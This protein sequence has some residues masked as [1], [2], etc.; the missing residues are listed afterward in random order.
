VIDGPKPVRVGILMIAVDNC[1]RHET[2]VNSAHAY[3]ALGY[4]RSRRES[5]GVIN[6]TKK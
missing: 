6:N 3:I 1:Q 4:E 2:F 5:T